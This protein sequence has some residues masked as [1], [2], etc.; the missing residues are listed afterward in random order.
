[1]HECYECEHPYPYDDPDEDSWPRCNCKQWEGMCESCI[2]KRAIRCSVCDDCVIGC[3][4]CTKAGCCEYQVT[5]ENYTI[6]GVLGCPLDEFFK[7]NKYI[8]FKCWNEQ[9]K[10]YGLIDEDDE[11]AYFDDYDGDCCDGEHRKRKRRCGHTGCICILKDKIE[12]LYCDDSA[13]A[14]IIE[15][16]IEKLKNLLTDKISGLASD[17]AKRGVKDLIASC[18]RKRSELLKKEENSTSNSIESSIDSEEEREESSEKGSPND[19]SAEEANVE[20][21]KQEAEEEQLEKICMEEKNDDSKAQKSST[22]TDSSK[23]PNTKNDIKAI[24]SPQKSETIVD[25]TS[26]SET[27]SPMRKKQKV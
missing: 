27:N 15:E 20:H 17:L 4:T 26:G 5:Q 14:D 1:M 22:A 3:K 18:A 9:C 12:C 23:E 16:D 2:G 11:D 25:V 21:Q 24:P 8:C 13:Q 6:C 19:E 10:A 7:S